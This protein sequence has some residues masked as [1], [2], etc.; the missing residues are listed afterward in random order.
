M[1]NLI[2]VF[3]DQ[4]SRD[5]PAI[6]QAKTENDWILFLEMPSFATHPKHHQQKLIFLFSAMR[7]F[8][9][10]LHKEGFQVEYRTFLELEKAT[11]L[12]EEVEKVRGQKRCEKVIVTSPSEYHLWEEISKFSFPTECLEDTRFICDLEEFKGWAKGKKSLVMEFFYRNMRKKTGILMEEYEPIGG[13]WNYDADNRNRYDGKVTI[14]EMPPFRKN[15]TTKKV[16]EEVKEH[17]SDHF[18]DPEPFLWGVTRKEALQVLSFFIESRL[19]YFG[20]YQDGMT[21][22]DPFLFHSLLSPYL[23]AGL[24]TPLEVCRAAEE[25]YRQGKASLSSVEGFIRQIIGWREFIRGIY[26]L[27]MP[28]YKKRNFFEAKR[29]LPSFFWD[30]NTKMNCLR[31]AI[32]S[33]KKYA[34]SH[35]IQRLMIT[36]NFALLADIDP[37]EVCEWYWIVY[38]D[39]FEWVELPNTLGMALFADG[40]VVGTKPYAAS[41]AYID[42]MSDFCK[43]CH[44]KVKKKQGKDACPFN[45]LY[46][47]FMMRHEKD[48]SSNPRLKF[49]YQNLSRKTKEERTTIQKECQVFLDSLT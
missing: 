48:L 3:W 35:H 40:G 4:L 49:A 41:G 44:Y 14:P 33:T 34:Y 5:L 2:L 20:R 9:Q 7:N 19:P 26:W 39:A 12:E 29:K 43:G 21:T 11:T 16:I 27:K 13:K 47:G 6:Q 22:K 23:N 24:L 30:G 15:E 18:G 42:R 8:A 1:K 10:E 25:V 45:I 38:A 28:Q 37:E 32:E 31:Y 17:F 36:G 46:W